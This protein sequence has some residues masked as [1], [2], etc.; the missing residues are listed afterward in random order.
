M[1]QSG[2]A[3]SPR[4]AH[5]ARRGL[6]K[7]QCHSDRVEPLAESGRPGYL[8]RV[9]RT[10]TIIALS[11]VLLILPGCD[12]CGQ[13]DGRSAP[14]PSPSSADPAGKD[15][16]EGAVVAAAEK[17][18]GIRLYKIAKINW[19][20]DPV[21]EELEMLAYEP[22][23]DTFEGAAKAWARG[24]LTVALPK[25]R[26]PKHVFVRRDHRVLVREEVTERERK[27]KADDPQRATDEQR[28]GAK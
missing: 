12:S 3:E 16:V 27:A 28:G 5:R 22:K 21:G 14:S 17:S 8:K 1:A 2:D 24:Q 11:A 9:V 15:L 20:P 18:G 13:G 25:V 6:Q 19:F 7:T 26:V 10:A 4:L 23:S